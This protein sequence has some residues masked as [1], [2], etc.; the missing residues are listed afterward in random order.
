MTI[1]RWFQL[2]HYCNTRPTGRRY[3]GLTFLF[4]IGATRTPVGTV[5]DDTASRAELSQLLRSM[6]DETPEPYVLRVDRC[7]GQPIIIAPFT[8]PYT[9]SGIPVMSAAQS[10]NTLFV[11][12]Q[13]VPAGYTFDTFLESIWSESAD[14]LRV[15]HFS[16]DLISREMRPFDPEDLKIIEESRNHELDEDA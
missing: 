11:A 5:T 16:C 15:G 9:P 4:L 3:F 8:P 10:R 7:S 2:L 1:P 14:A 13:L 12:P 6:L